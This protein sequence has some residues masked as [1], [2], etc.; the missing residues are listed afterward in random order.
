MAYNVQYIE[1]YM[2]VYYTTVSVNVQYIE[3]YMHVYYTTVSVYYNVQYIEGYMY[4]HACVLH[5]S[6]CVLQCAVY[7]GLHV[8]T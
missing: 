6:E 3:D 1:D 2:H 5:Y 8:R 7:R 4:V